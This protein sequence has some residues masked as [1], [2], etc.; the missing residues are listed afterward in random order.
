MIWLKT[1]CQR[2]QDKIY[3]GQE[4]KA[5]LPLLRL[6]DLCGAGGSLGAKP[7]CAGRGGER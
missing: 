6:H 2:Y 1:F 4:K 3:R 5:V 7:Q